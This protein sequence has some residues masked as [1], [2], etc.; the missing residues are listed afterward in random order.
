VT[1]NEL[2]RLR[3]RLGLSQKSFADLV[4]TTWNTVARW[5]RGEMT[6]QP[7]MDRLI[8]LSVAGKKPMP[9]YNAGRGGHAPGHLREWFTDY[10]E[11]GK[12]S[13][14]M[15][16][17]ALTLDWLYGQLWN[18][19]DIMPSG[20]CQELDMPLGSTYARAVRSLRRASKGKGRA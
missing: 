20:L 7:A 11:T 18:C 17:K 2:R 19:C 15:D 10:I 8:Q 3:R 16:E 14:E 1:A 13:E 6:M 9:R 12:I 4:G 5:E